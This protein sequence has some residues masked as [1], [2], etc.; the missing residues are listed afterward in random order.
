L[1]DRLAQLWESVGTR[2]VVEIAILAVAIY[3]VLR[4]LGKTRGAGLV[5]GLG[6]VAVGLF[7]VAQ[8][9][10][11]SFDLTVLGRVLDYLLTTVLLGLLVIFQPELRR[12]L[13][14]LGRY[15]ILRYFVHSPQH[16]VADKL[17]DAAEAMSRDCVGALIAIEREMALAVY[18]ETGERIDGEVSATLLRA[19]FGKRSPLHDGAVILC[20][21]RV[22][23]AACQLP[24]GQPPEASGVHMG[25]R[26]RAALCL[27]E[28]TDA[29]LLVVSEETGRISLAVGG[30]LEPVPRDALA[31]RLAAL[32][33]S[34]DKGEI[35]RR[36]GTPPPPDVPR[37]PLAA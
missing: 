22:A 23:A 26:H 16:P 17:A 36:R 37:A 24:L 11:A 20:D 28:E 33:D 10:I 18:V 19:L 5:R 6:L 8:V 1:N 29:V 30:R 12:G 34:R 27:S 32:L 21:G 31:R 13:M 7:L 3:L 15:R 35:R 4:F 25:M 2:D 9:V 14:V